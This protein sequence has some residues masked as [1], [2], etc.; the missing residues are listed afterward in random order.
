MTRFLT[1]YLIAVFTAVSLTG[2]IWRSGR[3]AATETNTETASANTNISVPTPSAKRPASRFK[4]LDQGDFIVS[5]GT[6]R[7]QIYLGIDEQIKDEKILE[8]AADKL[9]RAFI[10][11]KDVTLRIAECGEAN[12]SYDPN[13]Q[14]VT[15]CLELMET[16]YRLF[17]RAGISDDA[18]YGK[19]F[20]AVRFIFLHEVAHALIDVYDIPITGSEEDAADRC[21]AFINITELGDDGVRA[22]FA[23]A[24]AL[25]Q[26]SKDDKAGR[27]NMSDEHLLSGQRS[28]NSLC[29][30]YGSDPKKYRNIV[31]D[32]YLPT[33]RADTCEE[34][35]KRTSQSW[36][37]LLDPWRKN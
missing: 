20:D 25:S 29:M 24:D 33:E 14:T 1:F 11:P 28:F 8:K 34:E 23:A 6:V 18:A 16:Y 19:M 13:T 9:N 12:S 22:V 35:F 26:E 36:A 27:A 30:I 5:S 4:Q 32:K 37:V 21:S 15:V 17:K 2:C 3:D 10:L 31:T 7:N